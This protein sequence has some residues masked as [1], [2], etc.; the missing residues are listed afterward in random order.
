MYAWYFILYFSGR[1]TYNLTNYNVLLLIDASDEELFQIG[2]RSKG[3]PLIK[4][5]CSPEHLA[6]EKARDAKKRNLL[7]DILKKGKSK[8]IIAKSTEDLTWFV[9]MQ[10]I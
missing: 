10:Q 9:L 4:I 2:I 3:N 1:L 6:E 5:I 7:L 8:A